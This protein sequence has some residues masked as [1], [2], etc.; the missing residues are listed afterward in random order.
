M[1][2]LRRSSAAVAKGGASD[3]SHRQ[4][5]HLA[6]PVGSARF[7]S[8]S[9][10]QHPSSELV[11]R[12]GSARRCFDSRGAN[13][14]SPG[15]SS[16]G[17]ARAVRYRRI[18]GPNVLGFPWRALLDEPTNTI[19]IVD[20]DPTARKLAEAAAVPLEVRCVSFESAIGFL[21][22]FDF[23]QPGCVVSDICMPGMD[24]LELQR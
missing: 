17:S 22:A 4:A 3:L 12:K 2:E 24:G 6:H 19:F 9:A 18:L 8:V 13:H 1:W 10:P 16:V 5:R 21:D 15:T 20:D 14:R 11:R 23:R 7:S